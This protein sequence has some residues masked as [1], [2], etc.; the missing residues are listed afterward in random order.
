MAGKNEVV[1]MNRA[2]KQVLG[3][4]VSSSDL[5]PDGS[6]WQVVPLVAPSTEPA[7]TDP[8]AWRV[9]THTRGS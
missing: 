5:S 2:T 6:T 1:L 9:R 7:A 4:P 3:A 8:T